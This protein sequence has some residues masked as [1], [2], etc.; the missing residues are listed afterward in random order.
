MR[1]AKGYCEWIWWGVISPPVNL[2]NKVTHTWPACAFTAWKVGIQNFKG[3]KFFWASQIAANLHKFINNHKLQWHI[4]FHGIWT[5]SS[6]LILVHFV[7]LN[8]NVR[9][10]APTQAQA[11]SARRGGGAPTR[12]WRTGAVARLHCRRRS[13][14]SHYV[15]AAHVGR[16]GNQ[17]QAL[18]VTGS[19]DMATGDWQFG[20]W[21]GAQGSWQRAGVAAGRLARRFFYFYILYFRFL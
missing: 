2:R 18:G 16:R 3:R 10:C 11:A 1:P 6:T 15:S 17:R 19:Q 5:N 20:C 21:A 7:G 8:F 14:P 13:E 4:Y 12:R 9:H